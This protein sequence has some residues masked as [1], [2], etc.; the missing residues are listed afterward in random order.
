MLYSGYV[1]VKP[2]I[3]N[4]HSI[5]AN[6]S[7]SV[8]YANATHNGHPHSRNYLENIENF[9]LK[10]ELFSYHHSFI[11][12]PAFYVQ[13]LGFMWDEA[14][15]QFI[16]KTP[17]INIFKQP[18]FHNTEYMPCNSQ[19]HDNDYLRARPQLKKRLVLTTY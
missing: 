7:Q 2:E 1:N 4:R 18:H 5:T 11:V 12:A 14:I 6:Y 8:H 9:N 19:F 15:F 10:S 17:P 3:E 16:L 13:Y